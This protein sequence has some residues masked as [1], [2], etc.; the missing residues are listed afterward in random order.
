MTNDELRADNEERVREIRALRLAWVKIVSV[1][2]PGECQA[3][4][5][6][7]NRRLPVYEVPTVPTPDCTCRPASTCLVL[8]CE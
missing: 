5:E 6:L 8:A 1:G 3:C 4:R 7:T 2:G